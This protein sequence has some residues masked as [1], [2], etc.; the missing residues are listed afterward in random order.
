M[1]ILTT[2]QSR[3][4]RDV[5]WAYF[6]T[7][8]IGQ[9]EDITCDDDDI[10]D[11]PEGYDVEYKSG[12]TKIVLVCKD[13]D[14]VIKIPTYGECEDDWTSAWVGAYSVELDARGYDVERNDYCQ[15]E[16]ALYECAQEQGVDKFFVPTEYVGEVFGIPVYVQPKITYLYSKG[17]HSNEDEF[18]Y[19]SI[20]NSDMIDP[21]VGAELLMYYTIDE[22]RAFLEFVRS[23]GI[24]DLDAVRNGWI[25]PEYGRYVFWDYAGF[26]N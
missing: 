8:S 22:V 13:D 18:T 26:H 1:S 19:A 17:N 6:Q 24:N 5:V 11:P 23:F 12:A 20:A 25:A 16:M 4:V 21:S 10:C 3:Y 15:L 2:E 7:N 14:F 9:W